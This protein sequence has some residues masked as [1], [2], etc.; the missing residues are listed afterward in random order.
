MAQT[1]IDQNQILRIRQGL[2]CSEEEA[3]EIY[4]ADKA[5]DRG[6]RMEFDLP[7]ELEKEA[8]KMANV[9]ERKRKA[10]TVYNFDT[11]QKK[12]KENPTK[13]GII[14]EIAK[15]LAEAS[16]N[17]CTDVN[18]TNPERQIAFIIGDNTYE[19]TLVQ[20]RKPKA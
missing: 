11:S 9:T 16:E 14:S 18:I 2:R 1:R 17:A 13:S 12:R 20:K 3:I 4:L 5:I 6:E 7:P 10:P 8:K 19:L 15:F